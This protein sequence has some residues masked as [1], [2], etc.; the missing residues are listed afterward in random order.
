MKKL[1]FMI[2][3]MQFLIVNFVFAK[4]YDLK[5]AGDMKVITEYTI[6]NYADK[7]TVEDLDTIKLGK[8]GD[9]KDIE[10]I[11]LEKENGKIFLLSKYAIDCKSYN[12][13]QKDD[14]TWEKCSLR[15]YLNKTFYDNAFSSS[16]KEL[17][18][19]TDVVNNDI[20]KYG[21]KSGNDTKDKIYLLSVDEV[22]KICL[23]RKYANR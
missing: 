12:E 23:S 6:N 3:A 9:G 19:T 7:K 11:S 17:I 1:L 4:N 8:D 15:E 14:I 20:E 21:T 18:L 5:D 16:E 22:K 2:V 10:W 13:T